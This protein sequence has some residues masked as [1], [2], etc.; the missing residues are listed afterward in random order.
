MLL[1]PKGNLVKNPGFELG[2]AFWGVPATLPGPFYLTNAAVIAAFSHSGLAS[3]YLGCSGSTFLSAVY[4]DVCVSP[5]SCYEL[6]FSLAGFGS[7]P[8]ALQ[9]DVHWLNEDGDDLG[10]ALALF[11]P[12]VGPA[13]A[14]AWTL[15]TGITEEAPLAAKRARVSFALGCT[16]P[17]ALL[18]DVSLVKSE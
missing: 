7:Y 5:C 10:V 1:T 6:A 3:L 4:Q 15:H 16:G 17:G 18:D 13:S 2:L 9:A 12:E 11:V 14:G 8:V